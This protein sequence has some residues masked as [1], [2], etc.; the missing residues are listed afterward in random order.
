MPLLSL[1][2][3]VSG[4][5]G[6]V[7]KATYSNEKGVQKKVACKMLQPGVAGVREFLREGG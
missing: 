5:F 7:N 4:H 1:N 6:V 2:E 3:A